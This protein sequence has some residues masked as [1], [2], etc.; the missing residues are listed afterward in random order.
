MGEPA[1]LLDMGLQH[2]SEDSTMHRS[3]VIPAAAVF[4]LSSPVLA[5]KTLPAGDPTIIVEGEKPRIAK[6]EDRVVC[7]PEVP[8]GS[9]LPRRVCETRAD[10]DRR[11]QAALA[12]LEQLSQQQ[13]ANHQ[14]ARLCDAVG[15]AKGR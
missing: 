2:R 6:P 3:I 7:R 12:A 11:R 4:A 8:T 15:C 13:E 14:V 1:L 9:I 5:Q 10:A